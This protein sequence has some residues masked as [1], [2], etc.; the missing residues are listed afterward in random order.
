MNRFVGKPSRILQRLPNVFF[1]E[2]GVVFDDLRGC[3]TISNK[4]ED[5]R[6]CDTQTA[7]AGASAHD[8]RVKCDAIEL[9]HG[10]DLRI[11]YNAINRSAACWK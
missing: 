2:I 7:N 5:Q 9:S 4:I 6:D 3:H 1:F 10:C 8:E 11:H